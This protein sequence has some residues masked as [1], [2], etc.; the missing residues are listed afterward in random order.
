MKANTKIRT[1]GYLANR[2][3]HQRINEVLKKMKLPVHKGVVKIPLQVRMMEQ[4]GIDMDEC[5]CCKNK[6]MKLVKYFIHGRMPVMD[7]NIDD[8]YSNDKKMATPHVRG[9][10]QSRW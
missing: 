4:F 7:K 3:R 8:F 10:R 2:N 5:P 1:Y 6:T 9:N